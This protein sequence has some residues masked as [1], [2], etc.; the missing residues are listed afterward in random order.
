MSKKV[1]ETIIIR[2]DKLTYAVRLVSKV[3]GVGSKIENS[4]PYIIT[5]RGEIKFVDH[6]YG[7]KCEFNFDDNVHVVAKEIFISELRTAIKRQVLELKQIELVLNEMG[8]RDC[9]GD[10]VKQSISFLERV[11]QFMIE[12]N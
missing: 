2:N 4:N 8:L 6:L 9:I 5:E 10:T 11:K 12:D 7:N 3:D 1:E